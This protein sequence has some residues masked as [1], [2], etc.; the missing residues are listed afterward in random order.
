LNTGL[1]TASL[2]LRDRIFQGIHEP[3]SAAPRMKPINNGQSALIH[4]APEPRVW[5]LTLPPG[6]L[7]DK[8]RQKR[9]TSPTAFDA[10]VAHL[11]AAGYSVQFDSLF[12]AVVEVAS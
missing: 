11:R 4:M 1:T 9:F 5:C 6:M 8:R 12:T 7:A 3:R 10:Y 2:A